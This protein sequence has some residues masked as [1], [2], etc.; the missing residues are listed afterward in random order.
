MPSPSGPVRLALLHGFALSSP[1]GAV[2]VP[3]PARRLLALLALRG[4]PVQR[5]TV[6]ANLWP[7]LDERPAAS[8]LRSTLWRLPPRDRPLVDLD[9]GRLALAPDVDVDLRDLEDDDRFRQ[10]SV[11]ALCGEVLAGWDDDWVLDERE[12]YR[13]LRLHRLEQLAATA[14]RQ[15]RFGVALEASLAAVRSEPLRESAHREVMSVHLAEQNPS[16]ALRQYEHVRQVLRDG[17]GLA[18]SAATRALV[19]PLLGRPLG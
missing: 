16:E 4:H 18:P 15:G 13:Q 10:L 3:G 17:L 8:R 1:A 2:R 19:A 7:D 5:T 9:D 14:R 11:H 12:R 6:A